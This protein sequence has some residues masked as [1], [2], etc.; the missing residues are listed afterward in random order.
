MIN[1]YIDFWKRTFDFKGSTSLRDFLLFILVDFV[2]SIIVAY[3]F[4]EI[5]YL[6][7]EIVKIIPYFSLVIRRFHDTGRTAKML[8]WILVPLFGWFAIIGALL[9]SSQ[10]DIDRQF[11]K[12]HW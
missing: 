10:R 9:Q 2:V 12:Y 7:Y 8:L 3:I 11:D 1:A 5:G 4:R 6:V